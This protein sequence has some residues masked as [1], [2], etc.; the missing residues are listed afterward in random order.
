MED[1]K[2]RRTKNLTKTGIIQTPETNSKSEYPGKF[3]VL[4]VF[5]FSSI[6]PQI[7]ATRLKCHSCS[8]FVLRLARTSVLVFGHS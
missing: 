2:Q 3:S 8:S 4:N 1:Q 7:E 6:P 5:C